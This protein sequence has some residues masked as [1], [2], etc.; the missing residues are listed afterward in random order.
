MSVQK[1]SK[2]VADDPL[3]T[4]SIILRSS[5][6]ALLRKVAGSRRFL[7]SGGGHRS[8]SEVVRDIIENATPQLSAELAAAH[9]AIRQ[10]TK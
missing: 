5:H 8:V 6:I 2:A 9:A 4:T 7:G 1:T 3:E 10:D